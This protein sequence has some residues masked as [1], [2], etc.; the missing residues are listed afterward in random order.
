MG[1]WEA[2]NGNREIPVGKFVPYS[3]RFLGCDIDI[4]KGETIRLDH[5]LKQSEYHRQKTQ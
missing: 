1:K 5:T 2:G 4:K 3:Q